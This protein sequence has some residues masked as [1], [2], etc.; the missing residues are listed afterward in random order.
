MAGPTARNTMTDC[1]PT[2]ADPDVRMPQPGNDDHGR[3]E[4]DAVLTAYVEA[5]LHPRRSAEDRARRE[6]AWQEL[7]RVVQTRDNDNDDN[8]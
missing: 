8:N 5:S 6:A 3:E 7:L 4:L 2:C 1:H